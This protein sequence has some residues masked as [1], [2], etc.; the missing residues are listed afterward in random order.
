MNAQAKAAVLR[1]CER[2][3][4]ERLEADLK[5]V[6]QIVEQNLEAAELPKGAALTPQAAA[7]IAQVYL[8]GMQAGM[9]QRRDES[10]AT[11]GA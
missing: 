5:A 11:R 8:N 7:A 4:R 9:A 6:L 3:F 1:V 10:T 2:F